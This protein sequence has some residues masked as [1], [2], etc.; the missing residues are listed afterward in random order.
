MAMLSPKEIINLTI[1][2]LLADSS[3]E[4]HKQGSVLTFST[5]E[6]VISI[7][8]KGRGAKDAAKAAAKGTKARGP[9]KGS[10]PPRPH[11]PGSRAARLEPKAM[12]LRAGG[13]TQKEVA[14]IL[15]IKQAYVSVLERQAKLRIDA[16]GAPVA[17]VDE[18]PIAPEVQAPE[19][20][21]PEV[22]AP[23]VETPE[24]ETEQQD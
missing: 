19:V 16:G 15:Q 18:D 1:R 3:L 13:K 10:R 8:L 2:D 24:T 11:R 4:F 22:Q 14:E 23:E 5:P 12:A 20:Q 17:P 9:K 7:Q 6:G 21:A